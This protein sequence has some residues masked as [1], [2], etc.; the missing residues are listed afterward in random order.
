RR[1]M[2]APHRFPAWIVGPRVRLRLR[3]AA[4]SLR[5]AAAGMTSATALVLI[6]PS[7][8]A[9]PDQ[10]QLD[11]MLEEGLEPGEDQGEPLGRVQRLRDDLVRF[12]REPRA[13][14]L[15]EGRVVRHFGE[16]P[17]HGV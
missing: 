5:S 13:G 8:V 11:A 10:V 4:Y 6:E 3:Q 1:R 7:G 16:S 9:V 15:D 17:L 2:N 14:D 12:A